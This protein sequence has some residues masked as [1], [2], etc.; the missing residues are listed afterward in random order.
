MAAYT[1][2]TLVVDQS[3]VTP[4]LGEN[5]DATYD[6]T[7]QDDVG[8]DAQAY[9]IMLSKYDWVTNFAT[10]KATAKRILSEYVART[11]AMTGIAYNMDAFT[12]RIEAED[13]INVHWARLMR[14]EKLLTEQDYVTYLKGA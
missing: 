1:N 11:I 5:I 4:Y 3:D 13:M 2:V 14:I 10:L 12:T 8:M 6:A 9:V 7:M